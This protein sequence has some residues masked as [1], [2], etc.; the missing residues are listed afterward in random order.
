M[1]QLNN[2]NEYVIKIGWEISDR[3]MNIL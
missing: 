1:T 2:L 3:S